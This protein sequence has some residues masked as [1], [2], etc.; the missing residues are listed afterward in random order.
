MTVRELQLTVL[1]S[2]VLGNA[3][4]VDLGLPVLRHWQSSTRHGWLL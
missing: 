4:F 2:G 1:C 3:E